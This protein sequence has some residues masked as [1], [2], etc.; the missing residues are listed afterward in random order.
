MRTESI[1]EDAPLHDRIRAT[2]DA[3]P[4]LARVGFFNPR[5]RDFSAAELESS[6][7]EL[8][9]DACV[10]EIEVCL[11]Y[12][13]GVR[14]AKKPNVGSYELKH[15][16]ERWAK[17]QGTPTYISNGSLIVA[18]AVAGYPIEEV[19]LINCFVGVSLRDARAIDKQTSSA[20]W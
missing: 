8:L 2:M 4:N 19:G 13:R 12:L 6:R 1:P 7:A 3:Y 20:L 9:S 11:N 16:V 15:A 17:T 18:A 5:D 10:G 14:K